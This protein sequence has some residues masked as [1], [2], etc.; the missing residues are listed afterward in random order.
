VGKTPAG[1]TKIG[2]ALGQWAAQMPAGA[3]QVATRPGRVVL[4]ACDP[5]AGSTEAPNRAGSSLAFVGNRDALF[6]EVLKQSLPV[7]VASCAADAVVRDP[8]FAPVIA[9][10][11]DDTGA[12]PDAGVIDAVRA[13]VPQILRECVASNGGS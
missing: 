4:T 1:T 5:G 11:G 10:A 7:N 6:A 13:R 8:S 2:D 3:A 12:D 9:A